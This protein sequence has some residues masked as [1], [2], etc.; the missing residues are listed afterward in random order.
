[1]TS[2]Y[3]TRKTWSDFYLASL[4]VLEDRFHLRERLCC[5]KAI[6]LILL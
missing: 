4:L 2:A 5:A 3:G 1:M 6:V